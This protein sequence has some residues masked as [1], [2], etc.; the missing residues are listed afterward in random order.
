M[1]II[2]DYY[3]VSIDYNWLFIDDLLFIIDKL[4]MSHWLF[5]YNW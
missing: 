2:Y 3:Y 1:L 4:L 5:I